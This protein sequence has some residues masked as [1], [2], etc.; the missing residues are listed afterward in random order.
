[1]KHKFYFLAI[2]VVLVGAAILA[3]FAFGQRTG[4]ST[5]AWDYKVIS[6]E[7]NNV[8]ERTWHEDG[9]ELPGPVRGLT[10]AKELGAGGWELVLANSGGN[11]TEYWYKRAK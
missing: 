9:R 1:M 6:I 8:G 5:Q 3:E 4:T 11:F 7:Q 10:K 2:V